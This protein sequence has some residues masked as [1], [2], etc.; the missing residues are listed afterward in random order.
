MTNKQGSSKHKY[1]RANKTNQKDQKYIYQVNQQREVKKQGNIYN[2][3]VIL[4]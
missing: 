3:I 4:I 2:F 1:K